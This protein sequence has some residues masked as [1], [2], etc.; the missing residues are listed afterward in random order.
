MIQEN[1]LNTAQQRALSAIDEVRQMTNRYLGSMYAKLFLVLSPSVMI[2]TAAVL[3]VS[4]VG[5]AAFSTGESP[6]VLGAINAAGLVGGFILASLLFRLQERRY[7][8]WKRFR[9][10]LTLARLI[11]D[12]KKAVHQDIAT[13]T[14][15]Q[16]TET[17]L[18]EADIYASLMENKD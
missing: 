16:Q 6:L 11:A 13:S 3:V 1:P 4:S 18:H 9:Q 7:S 14:L 12:L 5:A 8:G 15:Q 2:F 17:L 10:F